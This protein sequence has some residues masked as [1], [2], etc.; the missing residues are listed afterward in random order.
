MLDLDGLAGSS[1]DKLRAIADDLP[2]LIRQ[3]QDQ[4]ESLGMAGP[5]LALLAPVVTQHLRRFASQDPDH[6]D[7]VIG[8]MAGLL[9][10]LRSD[11]DPSDSPKDGLW[12]P[13]NTSWKAASE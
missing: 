5:A 3:L 7:D 1:S 13:R 10:Q 4:P 9:L 12:E 2:E 11:P 8:R 6:L